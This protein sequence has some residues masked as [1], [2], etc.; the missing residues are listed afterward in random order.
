[1]ICYDKYGKMTPEFH[2]YQQEAWDKLRA[3]AAQ[4]MH[5]VPR[6]AAV[7]YVPQI[8]CRQH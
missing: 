5:Q 7:V 3:I 4:T 8:K 1:M 2:A 6:A